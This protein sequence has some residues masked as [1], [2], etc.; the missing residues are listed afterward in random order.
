MGRQ[1]FTC[2]TQDLRPRVIRR[3]NPL[4]RRYFIVLPT[5]FSHFKI[6]ENGSLSLWCDHL[7][8]LCLELKLMDKNS[9][10]K[11]SPRRGH[12]FRHPRGYFIVRGKLS[13]VVLARVVPT[14]SCPIKLSITIFL[15][16]F[17]LFYQSF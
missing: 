5:F 16:D 17:L 15:L 3:V 7:A 4:Y 10:K 13:S 2:S 8:F 9:I 6:D 12:P 14:T 1:I 11:K